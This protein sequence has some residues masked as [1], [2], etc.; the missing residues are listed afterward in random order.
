M[1]GALPAAD[2][3]TVAILDAVRSELSKDGYVFRYHHDGRPLGEAEG[4]LLLYGFVMAL[5]EHQQ[6][7]AVAASRWF[8]RNRAA[9]G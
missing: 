7:G 3:R 4:A 5:A 9:S 1:R 8:E 2:P 6:G